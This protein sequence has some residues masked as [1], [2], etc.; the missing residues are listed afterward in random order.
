MSEA[1]ATATAVTTSSEKRRWVLGAAAAG[2][3]LCAG[4]FYSYACSVMPGLA[5]T[6]NRTFVA[7]MQNINDAI[8]NPVFFA[9]F[10][11]APALTLWALLIERRR[12]SRQ[13]LRWVT[14]A[15]VFAGLSLAVTAALNIPLN[16]DLKDAGSVANISDLAGVRQH[17]EGPWVAWNV[18][19]TVAASVSFGCLLRALSIRS[20]TLSLRASRP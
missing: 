2:T 11:G 16:N 7:T 17:F 12:G 15:L 5:R 3:G 13:T 19:R 6:D 1:T 9:T 18:V 20:R 8:Q 14:G 10:I 4:L